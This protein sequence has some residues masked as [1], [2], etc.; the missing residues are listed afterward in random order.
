[1]S[2]KRKELERFGNIHLELG[3][4]TGDFS[5]FGF[6]GVRIISVQRVVNR[7]AEAAFELLNQCTTG[8]FGNLFAKHAAPYTGQ[9][10]VASNGLAEADL[11]RLH[12]LAANETFQAI[13]RQTLELGEKTQSALNDLPVNEACRSD[14]SPPTGECRESKESTKK[15]VSSRLLPQAVKSGRMLLPDGEVLLCRPLLHEPLADTPLWYKPEDMPKL[16]DQCPTK[17]VFKIAKEYCIRFSYSYDLLD[18]ATLPNA[19]GESTAGES[20]APTAPKSPPPAAAS[21]PSPTGAAPLVATLGPSQEAAAVV[22]PLQCPEETG[23]ALISNTAPQGSQVAPAISSTL[24]EGGQRAHPETRPRNSAVRESG[25]GSPFV[26]L[27]NMAKHLLSI[28]TKELLKLREPPWL[29]ESSDQ[30]K[31]GAA[32]YETL[33]EIVFG[34]D[35]LQE[36]LQKSFTRRR[37]SAGSPAIEPQQPPSAPQSP[38]GGLRAGECQAQ[39]DRNGDVLSLSLSSNAHV[40]ALSRGVLLSFLKLRVLLLPL[41][42]IRSF[43]APEK[44]FT[45]SYLSGSPNASSTESKECSKIEMPQLRVLDLSF[46][47]L[48]TLD[49]FWNTP[50]LQQLCLVANHLLLLSDLAPVGTAAPRLRQLWLAGNPLHMGAHTAQQ[51]Q[52]LLPALDLLD[53]RALQSPPACLVKPP[54]S[55]PGKGVVEQVSHCVTSSSMT[56]MQSGVAEPRSWAIAAAAQMSSMEESQGQRYW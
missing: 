4:P 1:M 11:P 39:L 52:Q 30:G 14:L 5:Q 16:R 22:A 8:M 20:T 6:K 53:G 47:E 55:P 24:N 41:N 10:V 54:A 35:H 19:S 43:E 9:F 7:E 46:N 27:I 40:I 48:C 31:V 33:E 18:M 29:C 45:A 25:T 17:G 3:D 28:R 38:F 42:G 2:T 44:R 56:Q 13:A 12:A 34:E 32:S 49:G 36:V 50:R 26:D 21:T 23:D 37:T 15:P 51:L